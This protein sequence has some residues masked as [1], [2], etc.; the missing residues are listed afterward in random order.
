[1]SCI[2]YLMFRHVPV[3]EAEDDIF[4]PLLKGILEFLKQVYERISR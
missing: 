2:V 3:F 1:M 4:Y